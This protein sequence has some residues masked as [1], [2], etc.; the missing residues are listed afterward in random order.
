MTKL[1]SLVATLL[2]LHMATTTLAQQRCGTQAHMQQLMQNP[3]YAAARA[4]RLAKLPEI[5]P[6]A[7]VQFKSGGGCANLL[8]IPVAVHFY[9]VNAADAD[10]LIDLAYAQIE[11]INNDYAALNLDVS[12]WTGA[13]A[14]AFPNLQPGTAC[15]EFCLATTGHPAS[16]GIVDGEPAITFN[17]INNDFSAQWGGYINF[18]VQDLGFGLL[19]YSPLGGAGDGDGVAIGLPFFGGPGVECGIVNSDG[20]FNLGRTLTHELGHY[21]FL[22]HIFAGCN[23]GDGIADTPNCD[24][25]HYGCPSLGPS[26]THCGGVQSLFMNYMDYVDDAC[27]Y[28]F[29]PGQG[30][31]MNNYAANALAELA[32]HATIV[33]GPVQEVPPT[34]SFNY[35]PNPAN[36]CP[37]DATIT[38]TSTSTGGNLFYSWNFIGAGATPETAETGSVTVT[39]TSSGTI[40]VTLTVFN[41]EGTD[42]ITQDIA[43]TLLPADAAQCLAQPCTEAPAGA[44]TL[45]GGQFPV[46]TILGVPNAPICG[47]AGTTYSSSGFAG[48]DWQVWAGESYQVAFAEGGTYNVNICDGGTAWDPHITITD[49]NGNIVADQI[50]CEAI[51]TGTAT[52]VYTIY[53]SQNDNCGTV[54]ETNNGHL[55]VSIVDAPCSI[56]HCNNGFVD[57]DETGLDCGGADCE[58]CQGCTLAP[59]AI[60]TVEQLTIITGLPA[61]PF[62]GNVG[63]SYSSTFYLQNGGNFDWQVWGG[64]GYQVL[65]QQGASYTIDL[66]DGSAWAHH[67]TITN[68]AGAVVSDV[69]DCSVTFAAATTGMYTIYISADGQCG[70][71][72]QTDNG[73][74][75]ISIAEPCPL[76]HCSNGVQDADETGVDCGGADCPTCPCSSDITAQQE[77]VCGNGIATM[78]ITVG[79]GDGNYTIT[80]FTPISNTQFQATFNDGDMY[81]ITVDDGSAACSGIV[82]NGSIDCPAFCESPII[83]DY[84]IACGSGVGTVTI[85]ASGGDSNINAPEGFTSLGNNTFAATFDTGTTFQATIDDSSELCEPVVISG[86]IN[87]PV[88]CETPLNAIAEVNCTDDLGNAEVTITVSGGDGNYTLPAEFIAINSNTFTTAITAGASGTVTID[89]TSP[90]DAIT[91]AYAANCPIAPIAQD[92]YYNMPTNGSPLTIMLANYVNDPDSDEFTFVVT[93]PLEGGTVSL[94]EAT[95]ELVFTP[96]QG[97]EG[98]V[99][100]VYGVGD[101]DFSDTGIITINLALSCESFAPLAISLLLNLHTESNTY[102]AYVNVSGGIAETD[103]S[104]YSVA[105]GDTVLQAMPNTP[106][107]ITMHYDALPFILSATATDSFGC[108]DTANELVDGTVGVEL[109]QFKGEVKAEGN[110][111]HW[112]TATERNAAYFTLYRSPENTNAFAPIAQITATGNS[113]TIQYYNHLDHNAPNGLSY[114]RL[115]QTDTDGSTRSLGILSLQRTQTDELQIIQVLPVPTQNWVQV[116]LSG[117][118]GETLNVSLFDVTGKLVSK[119]VT[120]AQKTLQIDLSSYA[121][122]VYLLRLEDNA[123]QTTTTKVVKQ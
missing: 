67:I 25:E 117:N 99:S 108:S 42:F 93:P 106:L 58:P 84:N 89:D 98:T 23:N 87:C 54:I 7:D 9:G 115:D 92:L 123:G 53:I 60:Y 30:A 2:C 91:V 50:G 17:Q 19:G 15:V 31:V 48:F 36:L 85:H 119:Y 56:D 114:Y 102:T 41:G 103:G 82:L 75:V 22:E 13:V 24:T 65:L 100:F 51:F 122:G 66:C 120:V 49:P 26:T 80:G 35:S 64:E 79:G 112:V 8:T 21:L 78:T 57:A 81:V 88:L 20:T 74:F 77:I 40:S 116:D 70:T 32:A 3:E 97:F 52:G 101:G 1:Y 12:N 28:M 29:T 46:T 18:F 109:Y 111:L 107:F 33:C 37:D 105:L 14:N 72:V 34:A 76:P 86:M 27:M 5:L 110:Y 43:V 95:G 61:V 11:V 45:T 113:N 55:E 59:E 39:P 68:S 62:C 73:H 96:E 90:C 121:N 16:S 104:T 83:T 63:D 10:C 94:N 6:N 118:K 47:T 71:S 38:F 44:Y 4:K 69:V